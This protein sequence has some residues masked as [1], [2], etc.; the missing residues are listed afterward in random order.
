MNLG[1][2]QISG[3]APTLPSLSPNP[4]PAPTQTL[5]LREGRVRMSPETNNRLFFFRVRLP[6]F[7]VLRRPVFLRLS[8]LRTRGRIHQT[9]RKNKKLRCS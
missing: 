3:D 1:S 9:F 5:G 4:K 6:G 2:I 7:S 8:L